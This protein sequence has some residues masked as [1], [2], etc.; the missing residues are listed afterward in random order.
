MARS[1]AETDTVRAEGA[2]RNRSAISAATAFAGAA[3]FSWGVRRRSR[4]GTL[5]KVAGAALLA[6]S[7]RQPVSRKVAATLDERRHVKLKTSL[8]V[9]RP[10][11]DV[12]EFLHDFENLPRVIHLLDNVIDFQ[13]GRSRWTAHGR[14][15]KPIEWD[16]IITRYV[17]NTV[18]GWSSVPGTSIKTSGS[19]RF[20]PLGQAQMQLDVELEYLRRDSTVWLAV[21]ELTGRTVQHELSAELDR[22]PA[23]LA[24]LP[25]AAATTSPAA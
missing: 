9:E 15:G 18:I 5:A 16:V 19:L 14:D 23:Y 12:F 24:S 10:V 25:S 7:V 6:E 3:L 22:L 8:V 17:P 20:R 2:S 11:H 21:E 13:N 1:T 4:G